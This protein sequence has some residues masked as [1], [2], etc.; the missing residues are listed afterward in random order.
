[1][2][3]FLETA[4]PVINISFSWQFWTE[5][6]ARQRLLRR[7]SA[8]LFHAENWPFLVDLQLNKA[9]LLD[10]AKLRAAYRNT[11]QPLA[12]IAERQGFPGG[13]EFKREPTRP[14]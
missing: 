8:G 11:Y 6:T 7:I 13:W 1:L 2:P 3:V 9:A 5:S 4:A 10:Q 12:A 14:S